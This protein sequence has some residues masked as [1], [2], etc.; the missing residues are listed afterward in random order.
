MKTIIT[1][2]FLLASVLL[3]NVSFGS[4]NL[5]VNILPKTEGNALVE[6]SHSTAQNFE[7][8]VT[9]HSGEVVYYHEAEGNQ[10][11]FRKKFDFSKLPHGNY[12]FKV[13]IDGSSSEH[14][15]SIDKNGVGVGE[16]IKKSDPIFSLKNNMLIVSFLNH[17]NDNV[18]M[19]IYNRGKLVWEHEL[20]SQAIVHQGFDTSKLPKG[21]Y[22]VVFASGNEL[23][24]YNL[25]RD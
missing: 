13:S 14:M 15:L 1:I 16:T 17:H 6:I 11:L 12:Q 25:V 24:E 8:S 5:R 9:A 3:S 18:E 22:E 23:Y 20:K 21:E 2:S 19:A 10:N 7:I 4:G